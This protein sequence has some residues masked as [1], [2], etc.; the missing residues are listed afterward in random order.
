MSDARPPAIR[1]W[2]RPVWIA[3][4]L[5]L[6]TVTHL[7]PAQ[8]SRWSFHLPDTLLHGGSY[9]ALAWVCVWAQRGRFFDAASRPRAVA[10]AAWFAVFLGYGA[11]DELTQ[12]YFGRHCQLTDWLADAAGVLL[13]LGIA[14]ALG[15]R[16]RG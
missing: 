7:P 13:G 16:R 10:Y 14:A 3:Y 4:W 6:F 15:S 1:S 5:A 9:A 2:R 11:F 12:P 8:A